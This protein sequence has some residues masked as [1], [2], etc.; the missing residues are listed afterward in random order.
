MLFGWQ[1]NI[2]NVSYVWALCRDQSILDHRSAWRVLEFGIQSS[3]SW[4]WR[5]FQE[6]ASMPPPLPTTL[7]TPNIIYLITE[8][9]IRGS[10]HW[11]CRQSFLVCHSVQT[12]LMGQFNG[13][14]PTSLVSMSNPLLTV[15]IIIRSHDQYRIEH[16]P[17]NRALRNSAWIFIV[18]FWLRNRQSF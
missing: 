2:E 9:E 5:S 13:K 16:A 12:R 10:S 4:L 7:R 18:C 11:A 15:M 8:I 17:E 6:S 14:L 3:S 1:D